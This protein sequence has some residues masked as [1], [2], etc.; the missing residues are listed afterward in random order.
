MPYMFLLSGLILVIAAVRG[1]QADLLTLLKGDITGKNNF[2]YWIISI[3]IIGA[4][5]YIPNLKPVSRA[6]L[7]LVII[8]LFLQNKGGVFAQFTQ[9]LNSTQNKTTATT[10]AN[11]APSNDNSLTTNLDIAA[12]AALGTF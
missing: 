4:V 12:K 2:I 6:F 5:G 8:V 10:G 9:A 3:L 1:T 7:A 11:A